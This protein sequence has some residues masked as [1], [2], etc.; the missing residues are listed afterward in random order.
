MTPRINAL[1][2]KL[3]CEMLTNE[4]LK[5]STPYVR[6]LNL[7]ASNTPFGNPCNGNNAPDK[8]NNGI[9]RKFII[10]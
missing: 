9:I 1:L 2:N 10:S 4:Y 6:G 8:K 7:A 5:P 3:K